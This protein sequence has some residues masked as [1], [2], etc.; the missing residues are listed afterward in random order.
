MRQLDIRF[1]EIRVDNK[2][3]NYT[4]Q[5]KTFWN[6]WKSYRYVVHAGYGSVSFYYENKDKKKLLEEI[7]KKVYNTGFPYVELREHPDVVIHRF[8]KDY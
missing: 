6:T 7:L 2:V 4:L 5:R 3:T 8:T 1:I